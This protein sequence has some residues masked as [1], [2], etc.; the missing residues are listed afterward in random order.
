[1]MSQLTLEDIPT[2]LIPFS[3]YVNPAFFNILWVCLVALG[4]ASMGYFFVYVSSSPAK[5]RDLKFE[6]G[7]SLLSSTCLG[8]GCLFLL[9]WAGVWV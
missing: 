7:I 9:L 6:V 5:E 4:I 1:M 8:Y 3:P 2:N